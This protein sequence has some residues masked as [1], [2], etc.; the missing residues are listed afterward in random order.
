MAEKG[1]LC[2]IRQENQLGLLRD[3]LNPP[4]TPLETIKP[5]VGI[6]RVKMLYVLI[7]TR[8]NPPPTDNDD[9]FPRTHTII[10][11]TE[12][13]ESTSSATHRTPVTQEDEDEVVQN[14]KLRHYFIDYSKYISPVLLSSIYYETQKTISLSYLTVNQKKK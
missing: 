11:V 13:K 3:N 8:A 6:L 14:A 5:M 1:I 7:S 9:N 4:Q 2:A 10:S 12:T